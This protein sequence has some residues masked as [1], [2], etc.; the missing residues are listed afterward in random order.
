MG[1]LRRW[2][3]LFK[4]FSLLGSRG[5]LRGLTA[6]GDWTSYAYGLGD[7]C[8]GIYFYGKGGNEGRFLLLPKL[9][10]A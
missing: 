3:E 5:F 7:D 1:S 9:R 8:S 10:L 2:S 6:P 4:G